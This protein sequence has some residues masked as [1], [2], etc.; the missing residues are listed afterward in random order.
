MH[1]TDSPESW[2][3]LRSSLE[4]APVGSNIIPL[5]LVLSWFGLVLAYVLLRRPAMY[6]GI[7]HFLFI[8]PPMFIFTGFT[9]EFI[10]DHI[11][12][13]WLYAASTLLLLLPG[14][15]GIARLHPYEYTYY[16]SLV[17]GTDGVFRRYETDYWLTCYKESVERLA[18]TREAP[19]TL[20]V[21]REAYIADYYAGE[22]LNVHELRGALNEVQSGDYVLVNTRT[23]ED[24]RVFKDAPTLF[25]I[26]RGNAAFCIIKQIP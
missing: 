2:R 20:Y 5:T 12:S 7:R 1:E 10:I 13:S 21:H 8:L 14:L 23:N 17:G 24:R 11:A 16:N 18:Q 3:S 9:F 4:I 6:D 15:V 25:S 19:I 26:G 22:N